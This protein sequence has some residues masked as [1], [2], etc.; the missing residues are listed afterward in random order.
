MECHKA[1]L[2]EQ[3][4]NVQGMQFLDAVKTGLSPALGPFA[5]CLLP[6]SLHTFLSTHCRIKAQKTFIEIRERKKNCVGSWDKCRIQ[7][8][9][10]KHQTNMKFTFLIINFLQ[11]L[12]FHQGPS[13]EYGEEEEM[14]RGTRM[15]RRRAKGSMSTRNTS[16]A[17]PNTKT[18]RFVYPSILFS[19]LEELCVQ[20]FRGSYNEHIKACRQIV[21]QRTHSKWA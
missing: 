16:S 7:K 6:L 8:H 20:D 9:I 14:E 2:V 17:L 1:Q 13:T 10:N 18:G 21:A 5:A 19:L 15:S 3:V 4:S 12:T 11:V